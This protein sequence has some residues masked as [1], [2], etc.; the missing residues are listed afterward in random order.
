MLKNGNQDQNQNKK[1]STE[2]LINKLFLTPPE[3]NQKKKRGRKPKNDKEF[4]N[5]TR[6]IPVPSGTICP[7]CGL[8]Y[9]YLRADIRERLVAN[10]TGGIEVRHHTYFYALH[11]E[12]DE[13]GEPRIRACYLGADVYDYVRRLNPDVDLMGAH[14][15]RRYLE[16]LRDIAH[17]IEDNDKISILDLIEIIASFIDI[18][19]KKAS[20]EEELR[21]LKNML[22]TKAVEITTKIYEMK[23]KEKS[24]S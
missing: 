3:Q 14:N 11:Y 6:T 13:E 2:D 21:R 9:Q 19:K 18:V 12:K 8:E 16:Y 4:G 7:R 15:E 17:A 10:P 24:Q 20:T 1:E 23:E 5:K 22:E